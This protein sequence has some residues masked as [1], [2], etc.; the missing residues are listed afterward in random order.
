MSD[1]LVI[2]EWLW[3]DL[4]GD[5]EDDKPGSQK[6]AIGFLQ[7]VFK[8]CDRFVIVRGSPFANKIYQFFK[9][10]QER[11]QKEIANF[12][13]AEFLHNSKKSHIIEQAE[14][15][16]LPEAISR[17]VKQEDHYLA[18]AYFAATAKVII[19]TDGPLKK[20]LSQNQIPCEL[21]DDFLAKYPG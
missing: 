2:D 10:A 8:K 19:T 5:N 16:V 17:N 9:K 18:Q 3:A 20:T 12:F 7:K 15:A 13:T 21:R 11:R 1:L 4:S 14:L 6:E